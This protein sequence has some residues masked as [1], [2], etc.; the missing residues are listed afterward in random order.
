MRQAVATG[1]QGTACSNSTSA[2]H[3][4]PVITGC[5]ESGDVADESRDNLSSDNCDNNA[6]VATTSS[7]SSSSTGVSTGVS[8]ARH[9]GRI[10]GHHTDSRRYHT[11]GAIEDF[12]VIWRLEQQ[13]FS[14]F[15]IT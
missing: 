15:S 5:S 13:K 6:D 4:I 12:K 8:R 7:A 10:G 9:G 2:P 1:L 11:T 3:I 14:D